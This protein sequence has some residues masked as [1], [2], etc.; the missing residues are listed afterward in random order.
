MSTRLNDV[1]WDTM[2][3][4]WA[5]WIPVQ[6]INFKFT[7]VRRATFSTGLASLSGNRCRQLPTG[8]ALAG[9]S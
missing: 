1:L 8:D 5:F 9:D 4:Q 7:P 3:A 2:K 6:L